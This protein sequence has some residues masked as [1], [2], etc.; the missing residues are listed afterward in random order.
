MSVSIDDM[1]VK[2]SL[3]NNDDSNGNDEVKSQKVVFFKK[4]KQRRGRTS[5]KRKRNEFELDNLENNEDNNEK[6][7]NDKDKDKNNKEE[8]GEEENIYE[9]KRKRQR[10]HTKEIST[11]DPDKKNKKEDVLVN[12]ESSTTAMSVG[13]VDQ[14]ATATNEIDDNSRIKKTLYGPKKGVSNVRITCRFDYQP[15][16]CKDYKDTGYCGYGLNCKFLHDRGDYKSGWQLEKEW[17]E[18]QLK[19]RLNKNKKPEEDEEEELP[20]ACHICRKTFENP[21]VTKCSHYFCEDCALRHHAK[22]PK[23]AICNKYTFGI[24]NSAKKLIE[25]LKE[26]EER[27][28]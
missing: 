12:Y 23:C 11:I 21:I 27:E 28:K 18:D 3:P 13:P 9:R 1:S 7:I 14:G 26:K 2:E 17:E 4:K 22:N 19:K 25:K 20:F 6:D 15:D 5:K 10:L 24:F 16:V 8:E